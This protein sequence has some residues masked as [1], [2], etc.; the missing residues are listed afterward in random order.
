M[1][2]FRKMQLSLTL[3]F[4]IVATMMLGTTSITYA[5]GEFPYTFSPGQTISAAQVNANFQALSTQIAAL[6]AK[7][8][9]VPIVGTYDYFMLGIGLSYVTSS[10]TG[11]DIS[12]THDTHRG[13]IIFAAD[14]TVIINVTGGKTSMD[15]DNG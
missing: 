10:E 4:L 6:Q 8:T 1:E 7:L 15:L 2:C 11:S 5:A 12:I 9:P 13:T 3:V 14:G